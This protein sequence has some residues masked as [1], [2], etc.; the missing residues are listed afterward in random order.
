[1]PYCCPFKA[2]LNLE[3]SPNV[4]FDKYTY[5][6]CST[7]KLVGLVADFYVEAMHN[8]VLPKRMSLCHVSKSS[9][10]K[11]L[12]RPL[13]TEPVQEIFVHEGGNIEVV[14]EFRDAYLQVVEYIEL[15]KH[16][17]EPEKPTKKENGVKL[18]TFF[19]CDFQRCHTAF[20]V[21]L[22]STFVERPNVEG[23]VIK[24]FFL[25]K[26]FYVIIETF[27]YLFTP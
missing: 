2:V 13:L 7:P 23:Y 5:C 19:H 9:V 8:A 17:I 22:I 10:S 20:F 26:F 18:Q 12:T 3:F 15:N 27:A 24:P 11:G 25:S 6:W 16:L 14:F 4:P 1:M 21:E